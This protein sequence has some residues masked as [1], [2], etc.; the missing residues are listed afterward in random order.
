MG[1]FSM[2]T[3]CGQTPTS[4]PQR[5]NPNPYRY[6]ILKSV[7]IGNYTVIKVNYP[8]ATNF[9]GNKI[10][11]YYT[12]TLHKLAISKYLDPHF[13]PNGNGPIARFVPTEQGWNL[14]IKFAKILG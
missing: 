11:V 1:M 7:Q 13:D 6:R 5:S 9:E 12:K 10:A 4:P 3:G 14:A 8:D 2:S